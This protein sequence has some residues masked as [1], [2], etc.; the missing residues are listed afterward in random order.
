MP[1][2]TNSV[3]IRRPP[4]EVFAFVADGTTAPR[5][6]SGV[7]DVS[8]V[9]GDGSGAVYRQGVKGPGGRRVAADYEV[10]AYEPPSRLAFRTVAG[11]VRPTGENRL[12]AVPEGTRLTFSLSAEL[13]TF[14]RLVMGGA[15]QR[16]MNAEVGAL[17][18]LRRVLEA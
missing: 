18:Q 4:D 11:P 15:V 12:E 16:S 14:Q 3:T 5:W 6:R 8:L 10:T 1:S 13:G 7:L 9:S 2:A 17:E